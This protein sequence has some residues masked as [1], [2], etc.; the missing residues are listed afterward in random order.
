MIPLDYVLWNDKF[1]LKDAKKKRRSM[2][3]QVFG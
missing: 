1:K 3:Q 2:L